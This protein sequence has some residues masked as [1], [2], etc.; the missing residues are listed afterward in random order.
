MLE[1]PHQREKIGNAQPAFGN[2]LRP[3]GAVV[4]AVGEKVAVEAGDCFG[5]MV[6]RSCDVLGWVLRAADV[7]DRAQQI[8]PAD[9]T[10]EPAVLRDRHALDAVLRQERV[11]VVPATSPDVPRARPRCGR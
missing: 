2:G 4:R 1:A 8:R 7:G 3:P 11:R 10:D 5:K 6:A 9:D